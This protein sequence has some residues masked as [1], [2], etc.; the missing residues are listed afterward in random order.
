MTNN[1]LQD[2]LTW[3]EKQSS[4]ALDFHT[5]MTAQA[6]ANSVP[7]DNVQDFIDGADKMYVQLDESLALSNFTKEQVEKIRFY[8]T[9]IHEKTLFLFK[10]GKEEL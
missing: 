9:S 1:D 4:A 8:F 6:T 2:L 5:T 3:L 7:D 10:Q